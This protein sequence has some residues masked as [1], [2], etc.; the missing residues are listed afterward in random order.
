MHSLAR[1]RFTANPCQAA[2]IP[3]QDPPQYPSIPE[4]SAPP[5]T[6]L[7]LV[8]FGA[9]T[10][11]GGTSSPEPPWMSRS[12]SRRAL[13]LSTEK[14]DRE[15][16]EGG[17]GGRCHAS[18]WSSKALSKRLSIFLTGVQCPAVNSVQQKGAC[19]SIP[20]HQQSALC[21]RVLKALTG[22]S[23][24]AEPVSRAPCVPPCLD[25]GR[26]GHTAPPSKGFP[27][28]R[29]RKCGSGWVERSCHSAATTR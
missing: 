1:G 13:K 10:W 4:A 17:N 19:C 6:L 15:R 21:T 22:N 5:G 7:L 12:T 29:I 28:L 24:F 8:V 23:T 20:G 26:L 2:S 27:C 25:C 9:V 3:T 16:E 14:V 18:T 11:A